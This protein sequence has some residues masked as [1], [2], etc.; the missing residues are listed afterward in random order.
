[1]V[2]RERPIAEGDVRAVHRRL[3][4]QQGPFQ[5]K[6]RRPILDELIMTLLSQ[7]TSD[8]NTERAFAALNQRFPTWEEILHAPVDEVI[9]AIRSGGLANRKAP[10]IQQILATVEER[11]GRVDL[12]RLNELDDGEVEAYLTALPGVGAKTAACVLLFSMGRPAFPVDTHVHRVTARLGW[13]P[14]GSS[15]QAAHRLLG[16][17]VPPDLR[18]ELHMQLITHGRTVCTPRRPRCGECVVLELCAA[19][20]QLLAE[21]TAAS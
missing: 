11:E 13:I 10:R 14:E 17:A 20:P 7:A 19:G 8:R 16:S 4:E 2:E 12:S 21:G 15:A 9:D 6:P 5:P 3:C 18:Y 1:M